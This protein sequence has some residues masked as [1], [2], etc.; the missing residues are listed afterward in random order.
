M[1]GRPASRIP[2][3]SLTLGFMETR[4]YQ[5]IYTNEISGY[6]PP[7]EL[8]GCHEKLGFFSVIYCDGRTNFVDFGFGTY[9]APTYQIDVRGTWGRMDCLPDTPLNFN[10][11]RP[12]NTKG[13]SDL[14]K[15]ILAEPTK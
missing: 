13:A 4:A 12:S 10:Q 8:R 3:P 1:Y 7:F 5:T 11:P 15:P 9:F 2:A 6:D 14:E